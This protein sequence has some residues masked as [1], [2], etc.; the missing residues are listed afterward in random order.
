MAQIPATMEAVVL[1]ETGPPSVL[2]LEPGVPVPERAAGEAL[3][4]VVSSSVNPVDWKIRGG[5]L[6]TKLPKATRV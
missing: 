2:K 6:P 5:S 3:L 4:R 1:C